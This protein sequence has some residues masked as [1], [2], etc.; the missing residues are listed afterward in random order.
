MRKILTLLFSLFGIVLSLCLLEGG[1]RIFHL[2]TIKD[3]FTPFYDRPK[4]YV[5]AKLSPTLQD[6]HY[7]S[8]KPP[9][10][11]RIGVVG[12]SFTF[13]PYMQ[14]TDAF[15]KVLERLLNLN[16][17]FDDRK[18]EV[19]NYGVPG[20]STTHEVRSVDRAISEGANILIL[21]ITLNDPESKPYRPIGITNFD[22]FGQFKPQGFLKKVCTYSRL[23]N[24]V[25]TRLHNEE[26]SRQYTKY[27]FDLFLNKR[28]FNPF[29]EALKKIRNKANLA[30]VPLVAVVFPLFGHELNDEY[31]FKE[32]HTLVHQE[33]SGLNIEYLDLFHRFKGMPLSRVQVIPGLDRHPNE[34]GHRMAGEE[35]YDFL[36]A[37][38]L[39]PREVIIKER[40]RK[41]TQIIDEVKF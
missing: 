13:A 35:I 36:E 24:F 1:M 30:K 10:V 9:G 28:T 37:K 20:Y 16:F 22:N 5:K 33:L 29:K 2:F 40:F 7:S 34:L 26:T 39:L 15:P 3:S 31:P 41:R 19:L 25:L 4:Y 11:F 8:E 17:S 6:Y 23:A 21:Q 32:L 14:F 18:V 12:D 38:K 27:F